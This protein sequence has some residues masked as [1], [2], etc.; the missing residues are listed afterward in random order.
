M[1]A[2]EDGDDFGRLIALV[3]TGQ[4]SSRAGLAN[5]TGLS[6]STVSQRVDSLL[7]KQLLIETGDGPSTGG[8]RPV[9][10]SLNPS[11][12]LVLAADIGA[13][14]CRLAVA[15][16]GGKILLVLGDALDVAAGPAAV[17]SWV[18]AG[19]GRLLEEAGRDQKDVRAIGL[20]VPGPVEFATGTVVR[21]PIMPGW[22]GFVVPEWFRQ[23]YDAPVL[24]DND[25]NIMALGE[26]WS[27][28][29]RA[30][31]LLVVKVGTG[32][33][34]GIIHEGL[35]HRGADGAAGDIGHVRLSGEDE[36]VCNCGN[37]GCL[38][39]VASGSAIA[40]RLRAEGLA[41]R[42]GRDVV[43]LA[44]SGDPRVLRAVREAGQRIGE[45]LATL[46][47]FYNPDTII[48][49]GALAELR[50]EL[51]AAI[52][53]VVYQ[54]ALPLATRR[55]TIGTASPGLH[56]GVVGAAMLARQYALSSAAVSRWLA[57][58]PA[59]TTVAPDISPNLVGAPSGP[60][61]R[62][63]GSSENAGPDR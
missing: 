14:H 15:D 38:E 32:I 36:T 57:G 8:R 29:Y 11:A 28:D 20:G 6:R 33:G 45:V 26:Y 3:A 27:G 17:L 41:V 10:L 55:L 22:D 1:V 51:L 7:R 63:I 13:S 42:S 54:R 12:G 44:Q 35:V 9:L 37:I 59:L 58:A 39:A 49:V 52:R 43:Q 19:F 50:D 18:V 47:N 34:C 56:S 48:I 4:A 46:V 62:D 31:E 2:E 40:T 30:Q 53:G 24:V 60:T 21:P 5:L 23:H 61:L 25:V 16:L